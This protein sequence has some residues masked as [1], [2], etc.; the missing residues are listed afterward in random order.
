VFST[1]KVHAELIALNE[2]TH[3]VLYLGR[4]MKEMLNINVFPATLYE[5]NFAAMQQAST[6]VSKGR[7]KHLDVQYLKIKE[8]VLN[9]LL[10]IKSVL[11]IS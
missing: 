1:P 5:D 8:Y 4:L 6:R 7:D 2:A 3:E 10:K 9:K 11:I